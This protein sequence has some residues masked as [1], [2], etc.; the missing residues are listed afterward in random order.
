MKFQN[1]AVVFLLLSLFIFGC[2]PANATDVP[3]TTAEPSSAVPT[4]EAGAEATA[5]LRPTLAPTATV[6]PPVFDLYKLGSITDLDSFIVTINLKNT[7]NGDLTET[8]TTIGYIREP[9]SAYSLLDLGSEVAKTYVVAGRTYDVYGGSWYL[10]AYAKNSLLFQADIPAS[11]TSG[12]VDAK[13]VEQVDFEGIP[14]YHYVLEKTDNP[15]NESNVKSDIEGE[16]Y[17]AIEGNYVLYSHSKSTTSQGDF[18]G[19]YEVTHTLS[20]IN[21]LTEITLPADFLPMEEALDLPEKLGLPLPAGT[22]LAEM[23]RYVTG[24]IGV[25]YY[26]YGTSVKN[27]D[28]FLD[29]YRN[30][31][32]TGGWTVSHIG[33][34]SLHA[35]FFCEFLQDCVIMDKGDAHVILYFNGGTIKAEFDWEH[36]FSPLN[37]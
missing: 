29:F 33:K 35:Y 16:F 21:Q 10:Y 7:T 8:T 23:I 24:G 19:T 6:W 37:E 14:T 18:Y 25:D 1:T 5:T 30:L 36:H 26:T 9:F 20:S 11:N 32:P 27:N 12:L 4:T 31:Q 2:S 17:V 28:E 3:G 22:I 13:F 34:V 15:A